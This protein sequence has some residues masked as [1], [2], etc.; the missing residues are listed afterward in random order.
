[1]GNVS[2]YV[3]VTISRS[4]AGLTRAGFGTPLILTPNVSWTERTRSYTNMAAV[5]ADFSNTKSGEYLAA[6]AIFGQSPAPRKIKFG[7]LALP[8]TKVI[9]LTPLHATD[10]HK[11][12]VY[13]MC[14]GFVRTLVSFTAGTGTTLDLIAAGLTSAVN[15][16][17]KN[18]TAVGATSPV[19]ITG[20]TA[21]DWFAVEVVNTDDLKVEETHADPGAAT[22]LAAI[23]LADTD[24]YAVYNMFN[25]NG[26]A[27]AIAGW[28]E[29]NKKFFMMDTNESRSITA[30]VSSSDTIDDLKTAARL[31]TACMYHHRPDQM[32][33]AAWLG[34][35]LPLTP[36]SETWADK[37]LSGV[38]PSPLT[39]THRANL[40]AKYAN[41]YESVG[42]QGITFQGMTSSGEWIDAVRFLDWFENTVATRIF[43]VKLNADKIPFTN[44]GIATIESELRGSCAE[45]ERAGGISPGWTVVCPDADDTTQVTAANRAARELNN[46]FAN[47]SLAGAVH[48]V[49]ITA[50][51]IP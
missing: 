23:K 17:S 31:R 10:A 30:A 48:L 47:F 50:R 25:S 11:Y 14:E 18:Y 37:P 12:E 4:S 38:D 24:F 42:S 36:G 19:V 15:I 43:N 16:A 3:T 41:G 35:V 51:V 46:C 44:A 27:V 9:T 26:M 33:G 29:S 32:A 1:M 7:R 40:V 49:N 34:K 13:V 5:A 39:D 22:D 20:T 2:N 45:G 21:G 28:V 8:P 6:S